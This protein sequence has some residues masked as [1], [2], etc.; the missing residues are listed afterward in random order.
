M[1]VVSTRKVIRMT[2]LDDGGSRNIIVIA[3]PRD[4]LTEQEILDAMDLI[5][6]KNII[7]GKTGDFV[8]KLDA[9]IV[10]TTSNDIYN[11]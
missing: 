9:R 4:D 1:G 7:E 8:S 2:F 11:P 10:E 3:N 6:Q 5:I